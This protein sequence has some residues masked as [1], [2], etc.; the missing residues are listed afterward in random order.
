MLTS[1]LSNDPKNGTFK[2]PGF[3]TFKM[4]SNNCLGSSVD[5]YVA[6]DTF[7][8]A[9]Y[10]GIPYLDVTAVYAKADGIVYINVINRHQS[11][12]IATD[13]MAV[14]GG[15]SGKAEATVINSDD[16]KA[17]F[18]FDKRAGYV[19]VTETVKFSGRRLQYAFP[20]H[21]FVQ[22]KVSLK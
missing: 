20:P 2:S 6:C 8:T 10:R 7:G 14:S 17:P 22:I 9:Q 5:T 15:F 21:A 19:P 16:L 4:F 12:A 18:A 13:I 1:L 11:K 3:Y